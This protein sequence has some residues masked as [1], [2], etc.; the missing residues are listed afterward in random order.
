MKEYYE[1]RAPEYD[2]TTYELARRV[3]AMA[4][5]LAALERFVSELAPAR[6]LDV[7]CGTGW[8]TRFL[9]GRVVVLDASESMLRLARQRLSDALFI[10][11]AAPLLP[12]L[13]DSFA[14]VFTSHFYNHLE[15]GDA[16][17]AFV[18][19]V[20]RVADEMVVV[21]Q[22]WRD[23]LHSEGR[24]ERPLRDGSVHEVYKRYLTARALADELGGEV[25]LETAT[26]I[27]VRSTRP[28]RSA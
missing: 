5:D 15:D 6:V 2:A 22:P 18:R 14:R 8:L 1:A 12:F 27:A 26:F 25:V 3:P 10:H 9:R 17:R 16:R 24:E 20:F 11:G 7:A 19:E 21:E 23:G 4:D 13:E 28:G